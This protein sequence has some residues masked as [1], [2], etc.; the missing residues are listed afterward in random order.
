MCCVRVIYMNKA[1]L[2]DYPC[3]L[4]IISTARVVFCEVSLLVGQLSLFACNYLYCQCY[5]L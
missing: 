5:V 2:L 1:V 3:L 4:V